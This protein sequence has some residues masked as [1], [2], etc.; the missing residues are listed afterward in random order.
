MNHFFNIAILIFITLTGYAQTSD[1]YFVSLGIT[2]SN[3]DEIEY[4]MTC[5]LNGNT[6]YEYSTL[7]GYMHG[8]QKEYYISGKIKSFK[9]YQKG[10]STLIDTGWF[11]NGIISSVISIENDGIWKK[12]FYESK[13][14]KSKAL[15]N[16]NGKRIGEDIRYHENGQISYQCLYDKN[17]LSIGN[18]FSY[19]EDGSFQSVG[20][21]INGDFHLWQ[22]WDSTGTQQVKDGSGRVFSVRS[23]GYSYEFNYKNGLTHGIQKTYKDGIL[24][25]LYNQENGKAHGPSYD[26]YSNGRLESITHFQDGNIVKK[27]DN[28]P[29]FDNPILETDITVLIPPRINEYNNL[30]IFEN[31]PNL[32]NHEEV[33]MFLNSNL[34]EYINTPH[35]FI[36]TSFYDIKLNKEGDIIESNV[37]ESEDSPFLKV[38]LKSFKL[39]KFDLQNQSLEGSDY[40]IKLRFDTKF[41]EK[42]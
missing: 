13:A 30:I 6:K 36:V 14:L 4:L 18:T 40:Q 7:N 33:K 31:A 10:N 34:L 38:V 37:S 28:F 25:S 24:I 39:M 8:I 1:D 16:N 26:Y 21:Y 11:E 2:R 41:T 19:S 29:M 20:E 32:I 35:D 22:M 17:G 12:K 9:L 27:E 15:I 5:F 23:D 3:K 42:K